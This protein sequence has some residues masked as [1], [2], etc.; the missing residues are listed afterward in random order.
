MMPKNSTCPRKY[1]AS[2]S[3]VYEPKYK[4]W[5]ARSTY[6]KGKVVQK[7]FDLQM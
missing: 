1:T 6:T 4:Y 2:K 3:L 7:G 5:A